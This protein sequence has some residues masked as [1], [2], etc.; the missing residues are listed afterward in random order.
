LGPQLK[1][2]IRA[3]A[4]PVG[5]YIV[6]TLVALVFYIQ[7]TYDSEQRY[8]GNLILS[9][10]SFQAIF[11]HMWLHAGILHIVANLVLLFVL[12]RHV[13]SKIG[14]AFFPIVFFTLGVAAAMA[15]IIYDGRPAIGTSGAIMG[16]LGMNLVLCYRKFSF[17][18]PWII[19][20][21]FL[22]TV[23][24]GVTGCCSLT[25]MAHAGGFVVGIML[26]AY[27]VFLDVVDCSDV[28]KELLRI[29]QPLKV[30]T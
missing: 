27:L 26:A 13:S 3:S 14:N 12:G 20:V 10:F 21:W 5:N 1:K 28:D 6:I 23:T 8:L 30:H 22:L 11:G 25:N 17:A 2:N 18:G 4:L 19:L 29:L 7:F 9:H 16:I 15:H 24:M